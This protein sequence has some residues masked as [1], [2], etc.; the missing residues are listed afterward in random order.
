MSCMQPFAAT[1][2]D[3]TPLLITNLALHHQQ[4]SST[5][6]FV[7]LDLLSFSILY[8]EQFQEESLDGKATA[9]FA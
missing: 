4:F 1:S 6:T 7:L 2:Y 8:R 3:A 9:E 5:F